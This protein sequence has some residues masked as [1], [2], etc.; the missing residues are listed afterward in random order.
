MFWQKR[1]IEL[2]STEY[3]EVVKRIVKIAGEVDGIGY[4]IT[5]LETEIADLRG[6]FNA[7]LNKL[8]KEEEEEDPLQP[9]N[10]NKPFSPFG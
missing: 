8:K 7:K 9:K 4:K 5:K 10:L 1:Q 6:R 3:E 2:K